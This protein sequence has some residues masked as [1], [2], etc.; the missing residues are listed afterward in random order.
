MHHFIKF[1]PKLADT[2][3]SYARKQ[4]WVFFEHSVVGYNDHINTLCHFGDNW[5]NSV[6]AL[7]DNQV[8]GQSHQAQLTEM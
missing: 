6:I 5:T 7:N 4:K 1:L 3:E 8:K 2:S